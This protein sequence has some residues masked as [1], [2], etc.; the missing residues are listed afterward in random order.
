MVLKEVASKIITY[1][2][3]APSSRI[4][5]HF[6]IMA[7]APVTSV[8]V[9]V[10]TLTG[11]LI[12]LSVK[13]LWTKHRGLL[14]HPVLSDLQ[15]AMSDIDPIAYPVDRMI[16]TPCPVEDEDVSPLSDPSDYVYH[17]RTYA[18]FIQPRK[19]CTLLSK[20][21]TILIH[22]TGTCPVFHY[23]FRLM[24]GTSYHFIRRDV[25]NHPHHYG[26]IFGEIEI[27]DDH[28]VLSEKVMDEKR[29]VRFDTNPFHT[30]INSRD[31]MW[32]LPQIGE[33]PPILSDVHDVYT[34]QQFILHFEELLAFKDPQLHRMEYICECGHI[35]TYGRTKAHLATK[36]K[37]VLGDPEGKEFIRAVRASIETW[38]PSS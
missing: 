38:S 34:I 22:P 7:A 18:L 10:K 3:K 37:H 29:Y 23:H 5:E 24:D 11:D 8:R 14:R 25:D 30:I 13:A 31:P 21:G 33:N 2:K 27:T 32:R 36:K 12:D 17:G 9:S 20:R 26:A 28:I 1:H 16:F 4:T 19:M 35:E 15:Y 6:E